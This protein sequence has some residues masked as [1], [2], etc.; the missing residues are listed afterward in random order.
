MHLCQAHLDKAYYWAGTVGHLTIKVGSCLPRS[1][2]FVGRARSLSTEF[3]ALWKI[4]F[5]RPQ[6]SITLCKVVCT[7]PGSSAVVAL[8]APLPRAGGWE[9]SARGYHVRAGSAARAEASLMAEAQGDP[10]CPWH[11]EC[12]RG[13]VWHR[14]RRTAAAGLRPDAVPGCRG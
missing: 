9:T 11:R 6:V 14:C 8:T 10:C 4:S 12:A 7:P 2:P 5:F 1:E 13:R 3:G